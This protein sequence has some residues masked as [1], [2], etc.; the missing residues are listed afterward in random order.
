MAKKL[1]HQIR[2]K[3]EVPKVKLRFEESGKV[4]GIKNIDKRGYKI[5][6]ILY[7]YGNNNMKYQ[8]YLINK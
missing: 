8:V 6:G 4:E 7:E 1:G 3:E 2:L 5:V